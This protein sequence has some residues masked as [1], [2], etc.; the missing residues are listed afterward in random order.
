MRL[1]Q[2]RDNGVLPL[3]REDGLE[4]ELGDALF[5]SG[6]SDVG[7]RARAA[8]ERPRPLGVPGASLVEADLPRTGGEE[9]LAHRVERLARDEDN[10]LPVHA[11]S[12][13]SIARSVA[14]SRATPEAPAL[15]RSWSGR[16][17]P[18]IG[19]ATFG[20]RRIH[21][22]DSCA[23]ESPR[24]SAIGRR[25][26]TRSRTW[27]GESCIHSGRAEARV[28]SRAVAR[29]AYFPVSTPCASVE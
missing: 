4:P 21:A 20:S 25:R 3:R 16:D 29:G 2:R 7:R 8:E 23:T 24:P 28:P 1:A 6:L 22:S 13:S 26:W 10:E 19:E 27:S 9:R 12:A 15:S 5:P 17:A 18:T 14:S 11:A